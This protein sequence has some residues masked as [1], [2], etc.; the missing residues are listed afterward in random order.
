MR[1]ALTDLFRAKW[2]DEI[3]EEWIRNVLK[4]RLDISRSQLEYTRDL[5]NK[6]VRDCIVSN[7][8]SLIPSLVLPDDND[9]HVLA[10]AIRAGADLIVT[11]NLRDFPDSALAM[12]GIEAQ[13]PDDFVTHLLD[14]DTSAVCSAVKQQRA[15]LRNPVLSVDELLTVFQKQS[16]PQTV[17]EL[18]KFAALL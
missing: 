3:H 17:A 7:Y 13:H 4:D 15:A 11:Y 12:W 6:H 14:L 1:L 18:R 8:E 16:L 2:T 10:A 5:M 9:R